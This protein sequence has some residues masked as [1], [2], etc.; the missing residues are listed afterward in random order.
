MSITRKC[1]R[2]AT[3]RPLTMHKLV[4]VQEAQIKALKGEIESLEARLMASDMFVLFMDYALAD[5]V[6][7]T[8]GEVTRIWK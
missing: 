7:S 2:K 8:T 3:K 6:D 4:R 5:N 1:L